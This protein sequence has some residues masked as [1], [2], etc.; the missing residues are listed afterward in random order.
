MLSEAFLLKAKQK[1]ISFMG[2]GML[3]SKKR[4]ELLDEMEKLWDIFRIIV[5][6]E[7]TYPPKMA[8]WVDDFPNFFQVG[9]VSIP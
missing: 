9:Y 7:L 2:E 3:P 1:L 6:R 8:F 4:N 5:S